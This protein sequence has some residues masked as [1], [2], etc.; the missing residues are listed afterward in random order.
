M[1]F[2]DTILWVWE[3]YASARNHGVA[4][5]DIL[6]ALTNAMV[7]AD[8]DEDPDKV[9]YL[10]PDRAGNLLEVITVARSEDEVVIHAMAM[11]PKYQVLLG[12][13]GDG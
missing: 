2:R 9:L 10:G 1:G 4:D 13:G 12:G 6:Q 8:T 11:R 3:I 5:E 7:V